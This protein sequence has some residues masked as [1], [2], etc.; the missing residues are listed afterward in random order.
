MLTGAIG[1]VL[2]RPDVTHFSAAQIGFIS[3]C[4]LDGAVIGSIAFGT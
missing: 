2:M 1:A 4:Y 3:S